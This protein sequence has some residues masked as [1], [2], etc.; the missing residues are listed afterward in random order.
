MPRESFSKAIKRSLG[1]TSGLLEIAGSK[2]ISKASWK[3][4]Q[5][6]IKD[7]EETTESEITG[8]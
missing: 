1:R 6:R 8:R 3:E 2:T 5:G 7:A 4:V